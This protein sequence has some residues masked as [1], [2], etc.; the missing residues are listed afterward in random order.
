MLSPARDG[1]SPLRETLGHPGA[2]T[3]PLQA[4]DAAAAAAAAA[5]RR[6]GRFSPQLVSLT[7][8]PWLRLL[9]GGDRCAPAGTRSAPPH[10]GAAAGGFVSAK[11]HVTG[12]GSRTTEM[13]WSDKLARSREREREREIQQSAVWYKC[14][15]TGTSLCCLCVWVIGVGLCC[16]VRSGFLQ[17]MWIRI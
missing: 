6:T 12:A 13:V 7:A 14:L 2:A 16:D 4:V 1:I 8:A 17:K 3:A 11:P 9:D 5:A 10:V 15:R